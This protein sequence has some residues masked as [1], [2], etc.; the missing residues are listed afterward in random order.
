MSISSV[1]LRYEG[2]NKSQ[3]NAASPGYKLTTNKWCAD[4]V[5][6]CLDEAGTGLSPSGIPSWATA[7]A[8]KMA[9]NSGLIDGEN[10]VWNG[11][12]QQDGDII[13]FGDASHTGITHGNHVGIVTADGQCVSGDWNEQVSVR[14]IDRMCKSESYVEVI[15]TRLHSGPP[16]KPAPPS[17]EPGIVI[18]G[19][20]SEINLTEVLTGTLVSSLTGNVYDRTFAWGTSHSSQGNKL[21]NEGSGN[22]FKYTLGNDIEALVP[23]AT[24]GT[25]YIRIDT[26]EQN[27]AFDPNRWHAHYQV[28]AVNFKV[29]EEYRPK[30]S[31]GPVTFTNQYQNPDTGELYPIA[32]HSGY[33]LSYNII[34]DAPEGYLNSATIKE[35]QWT[36]EGIDTITAEGSLTSGN[37]ICEQSYQTAKDHETI[38]NGNATDTRDRKIENEKSE[39]IFLY[40]YD[41]PGISV[42]KIY[43]CAEDGTYDPNGNY[44]T[45][46]FEVLLK[47]KELGNIIALED[48][49]VVF[50]GREYTNIVTIDSEGY[51][52]FILE[53]TSNDINADDG[54]RL[55]LLDNIMRY[56]NMPKI[57]TAVLIV[58]KIPFD[59]RETDYNSVGAAFG[60]LADIDNTVEFASFMQLAATDI[61]TGAKISKQAYD[62]IV[63]GDT[64]IIAIRKDLGV[65]QN[66]VKE[67]KEEQLPAKQD[68]LTAGLNINITEDNVISAEAATYEAGDNI[69]IEDNV[70]SAVIKTKTSELENDA[71][72]VNE[73]YVQ[74]YHDQTKQDKLTAGTNIT[75]ENNVIS[76]TAGGGLAGNWK[77]EVDGDSIIFFRE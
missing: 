19:L 66:D 30:I 47:D 63:G 39:P 31:Y 46:T 44:Y 35:V 65:V 22:S 24:E 72:F 68:K 75:I 3:V 52:T 18:E 64:E 56:Y 34:S 50:K 2:M 21:I 32:G 37:I 5:W 13:C 25:F 49:G 28:I 60:K 4:F 41:I 36:S 61:V 54:I 17:L 26:Y 33:S 43:K 12:N 15:L 42:K 20:P 9:V 58:D 7:P 45:S 6:L 23:D 71:K 48:I 73:T 16:P 40:G 1:A 14:T 62:V 8:F 11:S 67:I 38:I 53:D 29:P 55:T 57:T 59:L 10:I 76:S 77:T 27:D 51:Y 74:S 70:I 69:V